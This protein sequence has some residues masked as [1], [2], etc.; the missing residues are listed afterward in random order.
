M[1][2]L[3]AHICIYM[4]TVCAYIF[5]VNFIFLVMAALKTSGCADHAFTIYLRY[6]NWFVIIHA[7]KMSIFVTSNS[8]E[9]KVILS[10]CLFRS[11]YDPFQIILSK[12]TASNV[13]F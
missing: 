6:K 11:H 9:Y 7:N 10:T 5:S 4:R 2:A 1:Y 13:T 12:A 3:Y 8:N